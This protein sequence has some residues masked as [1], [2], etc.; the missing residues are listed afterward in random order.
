[1]K[2]SRALALAAAALILGIIA[3]S[4]YASRPP[5]QPHGSSNNMMA[6]MMKDPQVTKFTPDMQA[7]LVKKQYA[8][9]AKQLNL[10]QE[11]SD[12]FYG[13]LLNCKRNQ[14]A[15]GFQLLSGTNNSNA[16]PPAT[17]TQE[18]LDDQLRSLLGE[19]GYAQYKVYKA[20][21]SDRS[22]LE[23]MQKDFVD[24]PLSDAQQ[25]RLLQLIKTQQE[26][27]PDPDPLAF[28]SKAPSGKNMVAL[29]AVVMKRQEDIDQR[30]LHGAGDF[31][32]PA[33]VQILGTSQSHRLDIQKMTMSMMQ[34]MFNGSMSNPAP[35]PQ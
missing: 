15:L 11:Q 34:K 31:L 17:A 26:A 10:T 5:G 29:M 13:L 21:M 19:N 12:A 23:R 33:Q 35:A 6:E 22:A 7:Q 25:Q 18:T 20:G 8:A 9:L 16:G 27:T 2:T 32:S 1:M 3:A 30:V 24:S 28:K 14:A 4:W